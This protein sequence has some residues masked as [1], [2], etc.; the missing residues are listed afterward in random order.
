MLSTKETFIKLDNELA[1]WWNGIATDARFARTLSYA[2]A[3][4]LEGLPTQQQTEGVQLCIH[5]LVSMAE[6]DP[7]SIPN[8]PNPG[9]IHFRDVDPNRK[10]VSPGPKEG[11]KKE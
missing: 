8:V 1:K 5:T 10:P 9:L 7:E 11:P 6:N 2:R 3:I 4:A